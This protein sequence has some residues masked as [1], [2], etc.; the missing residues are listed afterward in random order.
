[1]KKLIQGLKFHQSKS[2]GFK[3]A[4]LLR[5]KATKSEK[6]FQLSAA[7]LVGGISFLIMSL[8]FLLADLVDGRHDRF[9]KTTVVAIFGVVVF[10]IGRIGAR[11]YLP[12]FVEAYKKFEQKYYSGEVKKALCK[13]LKKKNIDPLQRLKKQKLFVKWIH[14]IVPVFIALLLIVTFIIGEK[15][16]TYHILYLTFLYLILLGIYVSAQSFIKIFE[17]DLDP[18]K[19]AKPP[20]PIAPF[21][22]LAMIIILVPTLLLRSPDGNTDL[23][24]AVVA[25][26]NEVVETLLYEGA[27]LEAKNDRNRTALIL[28]AIEGHDQIVK[29]LLYNGAAIEAKNKN[30]STALIFAADYGHEKVVNTL[31]KNGAEINARNEKKFTALLASAY[32]GHGQVVK[33]LLDNGADI[34]AKNDHDYSALGLTVY[35]AH[36]EVMRIL[37]DAGADIEVINDWYNG[38]TVLIMAA[39]QGHTDMVKLLLEREVNTET[40]NKFGYTAL[41]KADNSEIKRLL[42]EASE[43]RNETNSNISQE[44]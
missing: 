40:Q 37:L 35:F 18:N 16:Q 14:I 19:I 5:R 39:S 21:M 27:D 13:K 23:M 31:I 22:N 10:Y 43:R 25:G 24:E 2:N 34:E 20:L 38:N 29:T 36:V 26:K 32:N 3:A 1:M 33:I 30:G 41:M 28:A 44:R 12:G 8:L 6:L 9:D 17:D 11:K 4:Y 42:K 7:S 15:P